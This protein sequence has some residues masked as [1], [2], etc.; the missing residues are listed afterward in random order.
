[1]QKIC[2]QEVYLKHPYYRATRIKKVTRTRPS[3]INVNK[4][5][6]FSMR[7]NLSS[8]PPNKTGLL[9]Y[10]LRRNTVGWTAT[11]RP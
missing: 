9:A 1:M 5:I 7:K 2:P 4:T 10:E 3:K 6:I 11:G 8:I